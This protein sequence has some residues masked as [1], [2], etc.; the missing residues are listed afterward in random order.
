MDENIILK[1]ATGPFYVDDEELFDLAYAITVTIT[2][3]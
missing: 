1:I 2:R 3:K